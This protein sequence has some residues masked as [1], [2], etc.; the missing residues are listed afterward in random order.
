MIICVCKKISE[1]TIVEQAYAGKNFDDIQGELGLA[2]QC[3]SCENCA[4]ELVERC[5]SQGR[6][7]CC[8]RTH[9]PCDKNTAS[10]QPLAVTS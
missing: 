4:R 7:E 5:L 10:A 6:C 1:H 9:L 3:G 8:P 2:T